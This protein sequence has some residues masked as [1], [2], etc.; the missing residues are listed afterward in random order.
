MILE[1][2]IGGVF[3]KVKIKGKLN[4]ITNFESIDI[5]THGIKNKDHIIFKNDDIKY[6]IKYKNNDIILI[7]ESNEFINQFK[8]IEGKKTNSEYYIKEYNTNIDVEIMTNK[9]IINDNY[10]EINY[11]IIDNDN[12]FMFIL[13]LRE[14]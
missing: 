12:S 1:I 9:V 2:L 11:K 8:F 14:I 5:D 4:N 7:R 13:E 6:T 3:I 10:I